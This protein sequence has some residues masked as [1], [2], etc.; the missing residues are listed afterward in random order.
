M[1]YWKFKTEGH[2]IGFGIYKMNEIR[3][4]SIDMLTDPNNASL[5]HP[6]IPLQ[7]VD[8]SHEYKSV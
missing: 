1:L 8:Y 4:R 6:I 5:Y 3:V 7:R 2:D